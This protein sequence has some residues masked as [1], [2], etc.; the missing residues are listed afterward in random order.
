[1]PQRVWTCCRQFVILV[2]SSDLSSEPPPLKPP[3]M[4]KS[5]LACTA[6]RRGD[7]ATSSTLPASPLDVPTTNGWQ[8]LRSALHAQ[9]SRRPHLALGSVPILT[10][11]PEAYESRD[12]Q[13]MLLLPSV[14][15]MLYS[16]PCPLSCLPGTAAHFI[17][18]T[19][20]PIVRKSDGISVSRLPAA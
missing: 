5:P 17:S 20:S 4:Q 12:N 6:L 11:P 2:H 15:G 18:S 3:A 10:T 14:P 9:I 7:S 8:S 13:G 16:R 19:S 1:M